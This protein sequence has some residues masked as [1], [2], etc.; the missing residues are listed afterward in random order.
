MVFPV[1]RMPRNDFA[2][3]AGAIFE[4]TAERAGARVCAEE[5]VEEITVA[6][7]DID[8]IG[9]DIRRDPRGIDIG[10]DELFDI[11]VGQESGIVGDAKFAIE[12]GMA[13]GDARFEAF[14]V[15]W[16]AE[17]AGVS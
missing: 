16:A 2:Q 13:E 6:M 3:N 14:F 17:T 11:G 12:N 4:G 15:R 7:F 1:R 8:E 10:F 9:A 5:F